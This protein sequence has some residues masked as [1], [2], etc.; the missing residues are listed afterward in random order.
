VKKLYILIILIIFLPLMIKPC[1]TREA[2]HKNCTSCAILKASYYCTISEV[3]ELLARGI[4][5][6][7]KCPYYAKAMKKMLADGDSS[8]YIPDCEIDSS[9]TPLLIAIKKGDIVTIEILLTHG[10]DLLAK[11]SIG[12]GALHLA[13]NATILSYLIKQLKQ[14]FAALALATH[15]RLGADSPAQYLTPFL[16]KDL[17]T[18]IIDS[19][20]KYGNTALHK[21]AEKGNLTSILLL[22]SARANANIPNIHGFTPLHVA[23]YRSDSEAISIAK[24]LLDHGA[25]LEAETYDHK[26]V[27]YFADFNGDQ[28]KSMLHFLQSYKQ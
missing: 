12:R 19:Q 8:L 22:L 9:D 16:L 1:S 13:K 5:P 23:A 7:S 20:D 28:E 25:Q 14:R 15:P 2:Q 17:F 11:D 21:A 10:A 27:Y 6:D 3:L 18:V 24:A 4:N 26:K